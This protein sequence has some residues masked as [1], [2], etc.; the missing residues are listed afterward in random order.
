[1]GRLWSFR[2]TGSIRGHFDFMHKLK[3]MFVVNMMM[4]VPMCQLKI[5][6]T[7]LIKKKCTANR[8][9][10]SSSSTSQSNVLLSSM[11]P[12][13]PTSCLLLLKLFVLIECQNCRNFN[14]PSGKI[15]TKSRGHFAKLKCYRGYTLVGASKVN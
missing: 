9:V 6:T 7:S 15:V 5:V 4:N 12:F 13:A 2:P 3:S 10:V 11:S 1:M 14:F 8:M